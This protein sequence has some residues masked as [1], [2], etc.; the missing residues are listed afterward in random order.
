MRA[1]TVSGYDAGRRAD[2]A[3]GQFSGQGRP[4]EHGG[5]LEVR[6][7]LLDHKLVEYALGLPGRYKYDGRT[8]KYI[9]RKILYKYIPPELVDRPNMDSPF[10]LTDWMRSALKPLVLHNPRSGANPPAG[11]LSPAYIKNVV[12]SFLAGDRI[13]AEKMWNLLRVRA[14]ASEVEGGL[15]T[16]IPTAEKHSC[17]QYK[18]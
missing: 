10:H 5:G 6:E 14:L 3:S 8:T 1:S 15:K 4:R 16:P 18:T 11:D 9:L 2:R 17:K 13:S 7:P 12:D